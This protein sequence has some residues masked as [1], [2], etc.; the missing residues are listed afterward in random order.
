M[1][2]TIQLEAV[3]LGVIK[4]A[5]QIL[6]SDE[7]CIHLVSI[8]ENI[9]LNIGATEMAFIIS[10]TNLRSTFLQRWEVLKVTLIKNFADFQ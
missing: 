1:S 7:Y 4:E 8:F 5:D 10:F 3:V 2:V 9:N 6:Y